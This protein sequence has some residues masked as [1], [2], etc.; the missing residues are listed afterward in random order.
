LLKT[1]KYLNSTKKH[2]ALI[3]PLDWGL[4]HTTRCIPIIRELKKNNIEIVIACN[5]VQKSILEAEFPDETYVNL[6]GYR[7]SYGSSRRHTIAKLILQIPK[8]LI[9]IK[10]ENLQLKRFLLQ[11]NANIIISDN[12]YGVFSPKIHSIFITHQLNIVTGTGHFGDR[13]I[14]RFTHSMIRKFDECWVPDFENG[15]TLAGRLSHPVLKPAF[16]V[17]YIGPLS[18]FERCAGLGNGLHSSTANGLHSSTSNG[19]HS[20]TATQPYI[21]VILSGPEPQRSKLEEIMLAQLV[22]I[23]SDSIVIRGLPHSTESISASSKMRIINFAG[24]AELNKLICN[25]YV[26]ISRSGYTTVMDLLKLQKKAILIPTPGQP[27]QEY[28][29]RYLSRLQLAVMANQETLNLREELTKTDSL[30]KPKEL[31]MEGYKDFCSA[32]VLGGCATDLPIR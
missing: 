17:R 5:S 11:F 10:R 21:L 2:L 30:K 28:L 7:L 20:S 14:R 32:D 4:G 12:R 8:I 9:S 1:A 29:G 15:F 25:A 13:L 16:P 22:K 18:R 24:A 3:A 6:P 19:L 26:V 23:D 31:P 27:E